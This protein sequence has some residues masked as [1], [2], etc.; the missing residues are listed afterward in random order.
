MM[1]LIAANRACS[2]HVIWQLDLVGCPEQCW[3][4]PLGS[5]TLGRGGG[6]DVDL[7]VM[8]APLPPCAIVGHKG[9][10]DES[11]H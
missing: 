2:S 10:P 11:I 6:H 9:Q 5:W 8:H 7:H 1:V 4:R 3:G